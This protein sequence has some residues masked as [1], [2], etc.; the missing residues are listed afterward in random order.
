MLEKHKNALH[1]GRSRQFFPEL[2]GSNT[3]RSLYRTDYPN[4]IARDS[5]GGC[6][7]AEQLTFWS[8][9]RKLSRQNL[10]CRISALDGILHLH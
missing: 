9:Y 5:N 3:T 4:V 1:H 8:V 10:G 2:R 7:Q 6:L